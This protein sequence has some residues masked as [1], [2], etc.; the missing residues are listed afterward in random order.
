MKKC[1][2]SDILFF[3]KTEE[4]WRMFYQEVKDKNGGYDL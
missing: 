1:P 4:Q 3:D 2:V